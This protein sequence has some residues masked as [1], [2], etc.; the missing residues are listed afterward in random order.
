M[1]HDLL[2]ILRFILRVLDGE[3]SA[4][5]KVVLAMVCGLTGGAVSAALVATINSTLAE[6]A[7]PSPALLWQFVALC[8]LL[9]L[10]RFGAEVLML[11][12]T[13]DAIC[14]LRLRLSRRV[15][16]NSLKRM[17][18][19]G[20]ARI[21][22]ALTSDVSAIAI[23]T[24]IAPMILM[25]LTLVGGCLVY[26]GWLSWKLLVL[27]LAVAVTGITAYRLAFS[28]AF[29]YFQRRRDTE[30][31]LVEHFRGLTDG[32]KELK[33]HLLR[34]HAFLG[35]Q[36]Q[37]TVQELRTLGVR[38]GTVFAVANS[39]GSTLFYALIGVLLF[40]LPQ[41]GTANLEVLTGYTL[42]ILYIM[43]P[44]DTTLQNI[45]VL[46]RAGVAV[47]KISKVGLALDAAVDEAEADEM[48]QRWSS[49]ELHQVT[50]VYD[51]RDGH[52]FTLGPVDARFTPGEIVFLV[53]GNGSGK[54]TFAKVL[55]G[56][57]APTD[58][59]LLLDGM[60]V[61]DDGRDRLRQLFSAVFADFYLFQ[62][63]L[64]LGG[65][66][67]ARGSGEPS[68]ESSLEPSLDQRVQTYLESLDLAHKV[69]VEN[70]TLSTLE[71]SQGQRKRLALL[72]AY[73][74]DRPI[75]LFDEWAADQDPQFKQLF[76]LELLPELR[77]R[78]KTLF[79]I[80]HDDAYF[81]LA[82]RVLHFD[83]GRVTFPPVHE[84]TARVVGSRDQRR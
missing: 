74:E 36:L 37:P 42:A 72:T 69:S 40:T 19:L 81:H 73:L 6:V 39:F 2:R 50:S 24:S 8:A 22:A 7:D 45:P 25:N 55:S 12:L 79:V 52:P 44:I 35:Q 67:S 28:R 76:Y 51:G 14:R 59:Q 71:L 54:T 29:E 60:P 4:R 32:F 3:G 18:E 20:K 13:A 27:V 65:A 46:T 53:G 56:L 66:A 84:L 21:F 61:T 80:S 47:Q 49:L 38:G 15:L 11:Q 58:G 62:D 10:T 63:L 17:E 77:R 23:A 82:D 16:A 64:G 78:G 34:R 33:L 68:P 83:F 5:L 9:P 57:Y 48:P 43:V 70:G 31:R 1:T 30:D 75:Y 26:L 41:M